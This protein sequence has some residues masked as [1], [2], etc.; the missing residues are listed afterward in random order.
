P[1]RF[2]RRFGTKTRVMT[3][4]EEV[5]HD[6]GLIRKANVAGFI[7][8]IDRARGGQYA[9]AAIRLDDEAELR[10]VEPLLLRYFDWHSF[11]GYVLAPGTSW[12]PI[13]LLVGRTPRALLRVRLKVLRQRGIYFEDWDDGCGLKI[14][15]HA[16]L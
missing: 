8:R 7:T 15:T 10:S 3:S 9:E 6:W 13:D 2:E 11:A 4:A 5:L 1:T 14:W 12:Q 16:T